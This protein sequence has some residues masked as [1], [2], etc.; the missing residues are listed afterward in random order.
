MSE[1]N[2]KNPSK[3]RAE[4]ID[5]ESLFAKANIFAKENP[6]FIA[7]IVFAILV[8]IFIVFLNYQENDS[9]DKAAYARQFYLD[10]NSTLE[11][12]LNNVNEELKVPPTGTL[13]DDYLY[14]VKDDLIWLESQN[15]SIFFSKP[16]KDVFTKESAFG[17]AM[18]TLIELNSN[19]SF[20]IVEPDYNRTINEA[21]SLDI[22]APKLLSISEMNQYFDNEYDKQV[23]LDTSTKIFDEYVKQKAGL[24]QSDSP[25]ERKY[26][27]AK[28]L[29]FLYYANSTLADTNSTTS[30]TA[31]STNSN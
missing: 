13:D 26:V 23:F 6:F 25:I 4:T 29:I 22:N 5:K 20:D 19:F 11:E 30:V 15:N 14:S 7:A 16:N 3:L 9:S 21:L 12:F 10:N 1:S 18:Q 24:L 31:A 28:K 2:K 27:E 8:I 17:L